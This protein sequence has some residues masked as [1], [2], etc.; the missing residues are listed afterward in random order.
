MV[1]ACHRGARGLCRV[2]LKLQE[3]MV[4]SD[5]AAAYHSSARR[6]DVTQNTEAGCLCM[7]ARTLFGLN[8]TWFWQLGAPQVHGI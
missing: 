7:T 6:F 3:T 5:Q 4:D 2:R 8:L 1:S